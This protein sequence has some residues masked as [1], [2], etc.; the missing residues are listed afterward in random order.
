LSIVTSLENNVSTG[1]VRDLDTAQN[2]VLAD[3]PSSL[4]LSIK[5]IIDNI[6]IDKVY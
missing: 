3:L 4:L 5:L 1:A 6:L 2:G